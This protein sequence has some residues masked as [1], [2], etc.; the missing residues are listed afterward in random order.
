MGLWDPSQRGQWALT[1]GDGAPRSLPAWV[2]ERITHQR[3]V[4]SKDMC[5]EEMRVR[6][7]RVPERSG[8]V[9]CEQ[10]LVSP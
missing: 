4:S 3:Q 2:T 6:A 9:V 1:C 8:H 10:T 7:L 5:P